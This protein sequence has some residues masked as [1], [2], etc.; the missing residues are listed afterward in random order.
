MI[1]SASV[2]ERKRK[3]GRD[4]SPD[5]PWTADDIADQR[6]RV[7][8]ITGA[9]SGIGLATATQLARHG[10]H[11]VLAVRNLDKGNAAAASIR[12]TSPGADVS[13]QHLDLASLD[14]VPT[15]P[16]RP[17][18]SRSAHRTTHPRSA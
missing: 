12:W 8:V 6:G 4:I 5:R 15:G 14:S 11:V 16:A 10:A 18:P 7:A 1:A 9:N 17:W 13:V 2:T 3:C